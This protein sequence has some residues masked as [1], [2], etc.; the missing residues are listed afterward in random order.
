MPVALLGH[1]HGRH[2]LAISLE[3]PDLVRGRITLGTSEPLID[4]QWLGACAGSEPI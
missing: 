3:V 1:R 2:A 4:D